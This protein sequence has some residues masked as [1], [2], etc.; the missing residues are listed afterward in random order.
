MFS[1]PH[2]VFLNS[3]ILYSGI[4][5]RSQSDS[6]PL[7]MLKKHSLWESAIL[8]LE[9][10]HHGDCSRDFRS[11]LMATASRRGRRYDPAKRSN[12][13]EFGD[14]FI[15]RVCLHHDIPPGVPFHHPSCGIVIPM[16]HISP[17]VDSS[18]WWSNRVGNGSLCYTRLIVRFQ[19]ETLRVSFPNFLNVNTSWDEWMIV[20]KPT[21][22]SFLAWRPYDPLVLSPIALPALEFY[23][24]GKTSDVTTFLI[25]KGRSILANMTNLH[26]N[27]ASSKINIVFQLS[28]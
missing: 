17:L 26:A 23:I 20:D 10:A 14:T 28:N 4:I 7:T 2:V 19:H 5:V 3:V 24:G 8:I 6:A 12:L 15:C 25:Y 16:W 13:G 18:L 22:L 21:F 1:P 11:C 27:C 9:D